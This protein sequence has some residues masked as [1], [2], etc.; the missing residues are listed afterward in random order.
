[1]TTDPRLVKVFGDQAPEI[2]EHIR[3][4][5]A[6]FP[7]LTPEQLDRIRALLGPPTTPAPRPAVANPVPTSRSRP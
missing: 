3:R 7:P 6:T 2:A 5:V 4:V 1:M